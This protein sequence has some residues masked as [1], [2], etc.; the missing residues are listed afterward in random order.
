M[1]N[2]HETK[3]EST[4]I[5]EK[6]YNHRTGVEKEKYQFYNPHFCDCNLIIDSCNQESPYDLI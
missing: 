4:N 3:I 5:E 1:F 2:K 6:Y